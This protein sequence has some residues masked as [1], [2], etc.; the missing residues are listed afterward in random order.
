MRALVIE[1]TEG[2]A[3]LELQDV[4]EPEPE[5]GFVLLDVEAAGVSFPDL[6]LT[7]GEYQLK[8]ELPFT[9]AWSAPA[10]FAGRPR[11]PASSPATARWRSR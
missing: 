3:A 1:R 10:R 2:P 8:P 6:L 11:A 7:R 5:E 9:P 4:P